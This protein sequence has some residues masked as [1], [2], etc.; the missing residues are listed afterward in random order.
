MEYAVEVVLERKKDQKQ[1]ER[2]SF[3]WTLVYR[4]DSMCCVIGW[5]MGFA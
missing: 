3:G 5:G 4:L 1:E 2:E